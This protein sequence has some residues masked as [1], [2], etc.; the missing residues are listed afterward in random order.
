MS[1]KDEAG[2]TV[3]EKILAIFSFRVPYYVG[4]LS[5]RHKAEGANVWIVRKP[6][7]DGKIYPWNFD[8]K[9]DRAASNEAFIRR[10]TNK[11]TYMIGEDVIPKN[12]LMYSRYMVLNELNNLKIK[13]KEISVELKQDIFN[14]LFRSHTRVTG[15]KLLQYLR[16]Y[17]KDLQPEDLGGFDQDFKANLSSYLDFEKQI[18][19]E[20][21]AE[22]YVKTVCEDIIRWKTIYGD[23][24][25]M[26]I[27]IIE[28]K[29]PGEFSKEQLKGISRL[30]YSG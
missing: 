26:L 3:S 12:S 4:P 13:D 28:R 11:C 19:G 6:D 18:F 30:R 7:G 20:R 5:D 10:M 16:T 17:D 27:K 23:D 24:N 2:S 9:V 8:E 14:H 22:D 29:Y 1:K 15:K 25:T 21:M